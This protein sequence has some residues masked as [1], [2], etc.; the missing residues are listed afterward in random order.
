MGCQPAAKEMPDPALREVVHQRPL[1]GDADRVVQRQD[2]AAGADL[3]PLGDG[4][5]RGA[6]DG[7]VG[8]QPAEG[9]E[10]ALRRPDGGEAVPVGELR[11]LQQEAVLVAATPS[12][13]SLAK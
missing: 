1:F 9:V 11:A 2:D 7:R 12:P 6:G 4:G 10:V 8:V 5:D 3:H 13:S